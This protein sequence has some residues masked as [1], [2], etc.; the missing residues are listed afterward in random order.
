MS[1]YSDKD[2]QN[3][4]GISEEDKQ[5]IRLQIEQLTEENKIKASPDLFKVKSRKKGFFLPLI[6]NL[7]GFILIILFLFSVIFLLQNDDNLFTEKK[8]AETPASPSN[9]ESAES[10]IIA[11]IKKD[12]KEK[13]EQKEDLI[14]ETRSKL[15]TLNKKQVN[16]EQEAKSKIKQKEMEL[17]KHFEQVL[18][19]EKQRLINQGLSQS[20]IR[21]RIL[22][23]EKDLQM[24]YNKELLA[25]QQEIE[26]KLAEAKSSLIQLARE[27]QNDLNS[28]VQEKEDLLAES[29]K[30]EEQLKKELAQQ[31]KLIESQRKQ[32]SGDLADTESRLSEAQQELQKLEE[33]K[34]RQQQA[35]QQVQGYYA[36][37]KSHLQN[38]NLELAKSQIQYFRDFLADPVISTI[39]QL[40]S[41]KNM[42]LFIL[43]FIE[44]AIK[45]E[46]TYSNLSS[47]YQEDINKLL[48]AR[49]LIEKADNQIKQGQNAEAFNQYRLALAKLPQV[50]KAYSTLL[51]RQNSLLE[52]EWKAKLEKDAKDIQKKYEDELEAKNQAFQE[53]EKRSNALKAELDSERAY[54]EEIEKGKI[55]GSTTLLRLRK[56]LEAEKTKNQQLNQA[57]VKAEEKYNQSLNESINQSRKM[58]RTIDTLQAEV[59]QVRQGNESLKKE[60]E[61]RLSLIKNLKQEQENK[62]SNE[63]SDLRQRISI[64]QNKFNETEEKVRDL[65]SVV[66]LKEEKV[67]ELESELKQ[68]RQE[69][70]QLS[71]QLKEAENN[72]QNTINT[73]KNEKQKIQEYQEN[74]NNLKGE[75]ITLQNEKA[76]LMARLKENEAL[77]QSDQSI[78]RGAEKRISE[79]EER[80]KTLLKEKQVQE[81]KAV[82]LE[83][84]Q[85]LKTEQEEKE[86]KKARQILQERLDKGKQAINKENY[87]AAQKWYVS[88]L[89]DL[90]IKE[91][92]KEE[93][94]DNFSLAL[95]K[96]QPNIEDLEKLRELYQEYETRE[97]EILEMKNEEEDDETSTE[98]LVKNNQEKLLEAHNELNNF[99]SS[100]EIEELFPGFRKK[101]NR[102]ERAFELSGFS[103]A[104]KE[105]EDTLKRISTLEEIDERIIIL[106]G[107]F[108]DNKDNP[109]F[110]KILELMINILKKT[111]V[112]SSG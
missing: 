60:L 65:N 37:I 40:E 71:S 58:Q 93:F 23:K 82:A 25:Y 52:E 101:I 49:K 96:Q 4:K 99:L 44:E 63:I 39:P 85:K 13:L 74:I 73:N 2:L 11:E 68:I 87:Q 66:S 108:K 38:N 91:E 26:K 95:L 88:I 105:T 75:L 17:E 33:Q 46:K 83:N 53:L 62:D 14:N 90:E 92:Q 42:D 12:T 34:E 106:E 8:T 78:D 5:D 9:I 7:S 100:Q 76:E 81:N 43:D 19:A 6:V 30:K 45:K 69:N 102:Y 70:K 41:R 107:L 98:S 15:S 56:E 35:L 18:E 48:E 22:Q 67:K 89:Q 31:Q 21:Q 94:I 54:L 27:Y 59:Q 77:Q 112:A 3:L 24:K 57:L 72:R 64:L 79:L 50:E 104:L 1:E 109:P 16:L 36:K 20:E 103:S 51:E 61:A 28:L 84:S 86:R 32:I 80:V 47:S 111:K 55:E 29:R 10:R 110:Q 97:A